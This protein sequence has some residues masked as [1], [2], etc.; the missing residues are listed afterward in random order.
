MR[1]YHHKNG[2]I[3]W[4]FEDEEGIIK[5]RTIYIDYIEANTTRKGEG[6]KL[7]SDFI[8]DAKQ[9]HKARMITLIASEEYGTPLCKLEY[10]YSQFGF[11]EIHRSNFG[12]EMCLHIQP[13]FGLAFFCSDIGIL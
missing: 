11:K 13:A 12:V 10:F 2:L 6:K 8:K 9:K 3:E 5:E 1:K 7:L 4:C